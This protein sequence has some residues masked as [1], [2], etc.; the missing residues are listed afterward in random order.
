MINSETVMI[1]GSEGF[2]GS[3]L[4]NYLK[5]IGKKV[6][7]IDYKLGNDLLKKEVIEN[8][9]RADVIIHLAGKTY[10]PSAWEDPYSM[11]EINI[12]TILNILEFARKRVVRKIIFP[13]TYVYGK[14]EYLPVD[15]EHPIS[16]SN[17]YTRSKL[18]CEELC[19]A[20]SKDY[21]IPILILRLFNVYGPGQ[22]RFF[23]ISTVISQVSSNK[24]TLID[25]H[26]KRDYVYIS[27]VVRAFQLSID[28]EFSE[29]EIFNIG[30]GVSYQVPEV[31]DLI[32]KISGAECDVIYKN[33]SRKNEIMETL[34]D[35]S[36]AKR[37]LGWEPTVSFE[38]GLKNMIMMDK[39]FDLLRKNDS[40]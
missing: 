13:S 6:V 22:A 7:P 18:L 34:A 16:A 30:S 23:L 24:I 26:P 29:F 32:L 20:Y 4:V 3:H 21:S 9:P 14:P 11:Y 38:K 39:G 25:P 8:L 19:K 28:F 40:K 31:V 10:V 36:K 35:I 33:I 2:I 37:L 27:D 17:P 15:E 5:G 12:N 1:T